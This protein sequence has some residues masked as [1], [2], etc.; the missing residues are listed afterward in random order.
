MSPGV[1]SNFAAFF[2]GA[3]AYWAEGPDSGVG[4]PIASVVKFSSFLEKGRLFLSSFWEDVLG[5]SPVGPTV[6]EVGTL[7]KALL[8]IN[9]EGRRYWVIVL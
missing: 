4:C 8:H 2:S 5:I 1:S 6:Q 3:E 7:L 9:P